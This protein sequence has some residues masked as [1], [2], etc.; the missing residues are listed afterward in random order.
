MVS[1]NLEHVELGQR[2]YQKIR[3]ENQDH[4]N[5]VRAHLSELPS[6][7]S[8]MDKICRMVTPTGPYTGFLQG[9]GFMKIRNKTLIIR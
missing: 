4:Y 2:Y 1:S 8:T 3:S 6:N 9:A 7:V 5:F